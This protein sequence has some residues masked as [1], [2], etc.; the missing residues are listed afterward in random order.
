MAASPFLDGVC[1][2]SQL[3]ACLPRKL[4]YLVARPLLLLEL[5]PRAVLFPSFTIRE[6]NGEVLMIELV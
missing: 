4:A 2:K 3:A 5:A 6:V 1:Y